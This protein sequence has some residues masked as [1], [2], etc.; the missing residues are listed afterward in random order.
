MLPPSEAIETVNIT[1]NSFDAE[2]GAAGGAAVNVSFKS[3]T[4]QLQRRGV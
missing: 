3:G 1:T 2:Q 4:N